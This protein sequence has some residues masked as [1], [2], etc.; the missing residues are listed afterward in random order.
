[1]DT[2]PVPCGIN[3]SIECE[4]YLNEFEQRS[5]GNISPD[6]ADTADIFG[7]GNEIT[8]CEQIDYN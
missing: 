3:D 5:I 7:T 2:E 1:M 8:D 6:D 4:E